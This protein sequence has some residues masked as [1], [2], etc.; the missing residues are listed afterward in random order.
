MLANIPFSVLAECRRL[1]AK[2]QQGIDTSISFCFA[3]IKRWALLRCNGELLYLRTIK[4]P[5]T[6]T[7]RPRAPQR[8]REQT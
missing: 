4:R 1:L 5:M 2:L 6:Q 8:S 3:S 7:A